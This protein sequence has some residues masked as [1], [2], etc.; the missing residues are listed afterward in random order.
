MT[1]VDRS[2]YSGPSVL[3]PR[4]GSIG[5]IFYVDAPFWNVDTIFYTEINRDR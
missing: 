4:K 2:A 5:N 3:I 1:Y